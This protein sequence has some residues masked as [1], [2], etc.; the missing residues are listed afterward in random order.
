MKT[1]TTPQSSSGVMNGH[2]RFRALLQVTVASAAVVLATPALAGN[3]ADLEITAVVSDATAQT[4]DSVIFTFTATNHGPD[5]ATG[6]KMFHRPSDG[7]IYQSDSGNDYDS[8]EGIWNIGNLAAH[9]SVTL[10]VVA[11]VGA[12]GNFGNDATIFGVEDD[13]DT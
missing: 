11:T 12:D 10:D 5:P 7:F 13:P 3:S 1:H 2:R 9:Q 4:G 6:V 8:Q